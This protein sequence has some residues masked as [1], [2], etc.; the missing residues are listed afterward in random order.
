MRRGTMRRAW[1]AGTLSLVVV[2][3]V[4]HRASSSADDPAALSVRLT[5]PAMNAEV[6]PGSSVTLAA[7]VS[8][9][10]GAVAKVDFFEGDALVGTAAQ[11]PYKVGYRPTAAQRNFSFTA[12]V[13][14]NAGQAISAP[15][16][17]VAA[18]DVPRR[19]Q[20]YDYAEP[21]ENMNKEVRLSIPDGLATVRGILVV[22][23]PAGGDTRD[24]YR[25]PWYGEWVHRQGFAFLGA[26][27]FTSH[28]VSFEVMQHALA[29]IAANSHHPE[30]PNVPDRKST[31]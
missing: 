18:G 6:A 29:R 14:A 23:N 26:R 11:S 8:K 25:R 9:T 24:W 12:R 2:W 30:L 13:A 7:D 3:L 28:D 19:Y 15:V 27:A 17:C 21:A 1:P 5:S 4:A 22:T 20:S 16:T 31:R 10:G